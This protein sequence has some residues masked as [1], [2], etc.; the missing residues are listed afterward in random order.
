M[1]YNWND[2]FAQAERFNRASE[3]L[4]QKDDDLKIVSFTNAAFAIELYYKAIY[5]KTT[6]ED[7]RKANHDIVTIF[8]S[9]SQ[10]VQVEIKNDYDSEQKKRKNL[11]EQ[12]KSI[13]THLPDF[14]KDFIW[15]LRQ[16]KS[17]FLS[18]RYVY[19]KEKPAAI[20]FYPELRISIIKQ[21]QK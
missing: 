19:E 21:L 16:V 11:S 18:F 15:N 10:E 4:N 6:G 3:L 2:I 8:K 9:L 17:A 20:V 12:E 5:L 1:D 13:K 7:P 14:S